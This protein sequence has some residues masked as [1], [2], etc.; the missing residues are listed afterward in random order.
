MFQ[1]DTSNPKVI[2]RRPAG[3]LYRPSDHVI[4]VRGLGELDGF[5]DTLKNFGS[6]IVK[7]ATAGIYD[8]SK[9]RFYVPFSSGQMR[10]WAQGAV[11]TATLGLVK[12][13]KFFNS[14]TMRTVGTVTGAVAAAGAAA[15]GG[16]MLISKF[17]GGS[18]SSLFGGAAK[19]GTSS[20]TTTTQ[21]AVSTVSAT[22]SMLP[23]LDTVLKTVELGSKVMGAVGGS[24]QQQQMGP[25]MPMPMDQGIGPVIVQQQ[26]GLYPQYSGP[27]IP[28]YANMG[29][30]FG[31]VVPM[32]VA[33]SGG[34][35]FGPPGS[36]FTEMQQQEE[37]SMQ[38][39][40]DSSMSTGGKVVLAIA[41]G[42][43]V[44]YIFLRK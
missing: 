19:A 20:T 34:G 4:D 8:P 43:I 41:G 31:P 2:Y 40:S 26:P 22:K 37:S 5:L 32:T 25:M 17:G 42:A 16:S 23:S 28:E 13:D 18:M 10:N 12:T 24:P 38:D 11:N 29:A 1:L 30:G 3:R 15:V 36:E 6:G 27:Y 44:Y 39:G 21:T 7:Y 9:N 14:Q 35:G 33:H